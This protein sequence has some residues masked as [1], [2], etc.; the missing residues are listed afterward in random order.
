MF[1]ESEN[2]QFVRHKSDVPWV[3]IFTKEEYRELSDVPFMLRAELF[4][5][6]M[7]VERSMLEF[8]S[9]TKINIA[10]FGNQLPRVHLHVMARFEDDAYFPEPMWGQKQRESALDV[11]SFDAYLKVLLPALDELF[12]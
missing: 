8:F 2:L 1:Y 5:G 10:S 7:V 3:K 6:A 12:L 9:P 4:E 11:K